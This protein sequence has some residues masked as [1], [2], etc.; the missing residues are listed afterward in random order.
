M[1]QKNVFRVRGLYL[2][3]IRVELF[4]RRNLQ[5]MLRIG[6]CDLSFTLVFKRLARTEE[7]KQQQTGFGNILW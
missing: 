6:P 4:V 1:R 7:G 5:L 3:A 2:A